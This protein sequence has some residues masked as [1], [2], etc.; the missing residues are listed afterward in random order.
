MVEL[1]DTIDLGLYVLIT[2][3]PHNVEYGQL[4]ELAD[5]LVLGTNGESC[6]GSSPSLPIK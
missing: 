4:V 5:T 3:V 6:E 2:P 1:A